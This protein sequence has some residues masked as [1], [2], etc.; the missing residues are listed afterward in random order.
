MLRTKETAA[1]LTIANKVLN[2]PNDLVEW[3]LEDPVVIKV[4]KN[5]NEDR[6][7]S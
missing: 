2:K 3:D 6:T 4:D 7:M 1:L 5:G